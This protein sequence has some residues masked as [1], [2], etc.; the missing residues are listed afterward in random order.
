MRRRRRWKKKQYPEVTSDLASATSVITH[1]WHLIAVPVEG[2]GGTSLSRLEGEATVWLSWRENP[3]TQ[4]REPNTGESLKRGPGGM[5]CRAQLL[6]T[7]RGEN[8]TGG[9]WRAGGGTS[10]VLGSGKQLRAQGTGREQQVISLAND[11]STSLGTLTL[12]ECDCSRWPSSEK[13]R[14]ALTT[15]RHVQSPRGLPNSQT[16]LTQI[17]RLP[18]TVWLHD[19]LWPHPMPTSPLL[20]RSHVQQ[21]LIPGIFDPKIPFPFQELFLLLLTCQKLPLPRHV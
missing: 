4:A 7:V 19:L 12:W 2:T 8:V 18:F 16:F 10:A 11:L 14:P 17:P 6:E 9:R 15:S 3:Q 20:P 1:P 21:P 5:G 13:C